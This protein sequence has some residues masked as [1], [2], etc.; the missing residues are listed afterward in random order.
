MSI[1]KDFLNKFI[2]VTESAA[3]GASPFI[4]QNDKNAADG[5]AVNKMRTALNDIKFRRV[6]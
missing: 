3:C 4:G 1:D 2:N 6:I 5:G